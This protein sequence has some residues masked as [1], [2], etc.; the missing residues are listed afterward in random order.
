MGIKQLSL[1]SEAEQVK[2]ISPVFSRKKNRAEWELRKSRLGVVRAD[3]SKNLCLSDEGCPI[4]KP[5]FGIPD[6]PLIDFKASLKSDTYDNWVHFFIDDVCFEQIWNPKYTERDVTL[7]CKFKGMFTPDFTLN[8]WLSQWQEQ[9]NIFRNR[10]IGQIAQRRGGRVI[11]T[12][13]W[14]FRRSFDYCFCGL[15][16]GGTVAI[17]TNGVQRKIVSL[18]LFL[19]GVFELER[20]LRPEAIVIYGNK[21]DFHTKARQIW[22]P[23]THLTH[24][25]TV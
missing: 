9:F 11:P 8:P 4:I 25:R 12:I 24:L 18:R 5:Y 17:S 16:E 7:L 23:N 19:Q 6:S 10:A 14:S 1:F 3:L 2:M 20:K 22:H 21:I 13:G 15:S